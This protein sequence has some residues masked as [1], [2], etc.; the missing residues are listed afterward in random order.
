MQ[1]L[2]Q[3][4]FG[5][6]QAQSAQAV[7][8]PTFVT[9]I[10]FSQFIGTPRPTT[11]ATPITSVTPTPA[12]TATPSSS[13][14]PCVTLIVTSPNVVN[15][16]GEIPVEIRI[17]SAGQ[18][19]KSFNLK[20]TFQS[21]VVQV[22]DGNTGLAGTQLTY[23]D[24]DFAATKNEATISPG[25]I[26]LRGEASTA[27]ALDK[28]VATFKFRVVTNGTT[29]VQLVKADSTFVS[30]S[31]TNILTCTPQTLVVGVG[32]NSVLVDQNLPVTISGLPKSD[33]PFSG[34]IMVLLGIMLI[35][36]GLVGR[37]V[38]AHKHTRR[39]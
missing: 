23:L 15:V 27:K 26:N 39:H 38:A 8:Q 22:M 28:S 10:D 29:E 5:A 3:S 4:I 11:A 14:L 36:W 18:K 1:I 37:R 30:E 35:Y 9:D 24:S 20:F 33:L 34:I 7:A 31:N 13:T 25:V 16:G 19:L 21:T 6:V 32:T 12:T 17:N 2:S